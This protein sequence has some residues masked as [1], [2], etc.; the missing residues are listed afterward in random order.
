MSPS[1]TH[2]SVPQRV[3][4]GATFMITCKGTGNPIPSIN[5]RR[6]ST[7]HLPIDGSRILQNGTSTVITQARSSDSGTYECILEN[8]LGRAARNASLIIQGNIILFLAPKTN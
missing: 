7:F 1:I 4:V 8:S 3:R 5:W 6:N 2:F